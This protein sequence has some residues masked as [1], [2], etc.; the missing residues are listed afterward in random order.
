MTDPVRLRPHHL[1]CSLGFQ[2]KGYSDDFTVNMAGIVDRL[3]G[4]DGDATALEITPQADA[5]CAPCPHKQG[6]GCVKDAQ[7]RALDQRH[8]Q[9]LG[10]DAGARLTWGEA[11]ARIVARIAPGD[12]ATLCAGCQWL[13]Y[14]LCEAAL[15]DLHK[16]KGRT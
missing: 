1:M 3:R 2:G 8:A 14:G 11:Q 13:D 6:L 10:L 15:S 9:I 4:P 12:L 7:I 5:I 16:A